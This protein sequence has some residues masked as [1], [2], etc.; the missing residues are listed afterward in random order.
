M[1][2][3]DGDHLIMYERVIRV[4]AWEVDNRIFHRRS[5]DGGVTWTASNQ[6]L[7]NVLV[8]DLA[9]VPGSLTDEQIDALT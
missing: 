9:V 2:R 8:E 4:S 3:I 1:R 5:D 6:G 7:A